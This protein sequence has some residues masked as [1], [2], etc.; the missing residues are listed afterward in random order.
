RSY[1]DLMRACDTEAA[2]TLAKRYGAER[3]AWTWGRVSA[4]SLKHPLESALFI[5]AQFKT[6][7]EPIAGS[8]QTPNVG[9]NVSMRHIS[10]PGNWDATRF[11]VPLGQSGDPASPHYKD[12][13][14]DWKKGITLT[15]PFTPNA[16]RAAAK[17]NVNYLPAGK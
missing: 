8:G 6:P 17:R 2:A 12:Q 16:V 4:A 13:F 1:E 14:D 9:S 11:V 10:T 15:L 5:G 3:S 7:T